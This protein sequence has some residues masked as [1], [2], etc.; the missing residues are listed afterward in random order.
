MTGKEILALV[1]KW[2]AVLTGADV[3]AIDAVKALWPRIRRWAA[4]MSKKV[5]LRR[6][7]DRPPPR[8]VSDGILGDNSNSPK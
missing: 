5:C 4:Q 7:V 8:V 6:T 3:R 2:G 1:R